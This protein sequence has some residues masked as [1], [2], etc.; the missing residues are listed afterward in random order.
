MYTFALLALL[1]NPVVATVA[2]YGACVDKKSG[3]KTCSW[4]PSHCNMTAEDWLLA[5]DFTDEDMTCDASEIQKLGGC[6][7]MFGGTHVQRCTLS[8][9]E[10][11][12]LTG[13]AHGREYSYTSDTNCPSN[14][15]PH[16][17]TA[18]VGAENGE[19]CTGFQDREDGLLNYGM[20]QN[21][22]TNDITCVFTENDCDTGET[23]LSRA[24]P[25]NEHQDCTCDMVETGACYDGVTHSSF[26]AFD[27]EVCDEAGMTWLDRVTAASYSLGC[28]AC[29]WDY[30]DLNSKNCHSMCDITASDEMGSEAICCDFDVVSRNSR[31]GRRTS[32]ETDLKGTCCSSGDDLVMISR[33]V[34]WYSQ[35]EFEF[36]MTTSM[37]SDDDAEDVLQDTIAEQLGMSVNDIKS[38]DVTTSEVEETYRR[39]SL[40]T[41]SVTWTVKFAIMMSLTE[42]IYDNTADLLE[43]ISTTIA[44]DS[45]GTAVTTDLQ[46]VT[47]FE[48]MTVAVDTD[49]VE[50][51]DT[52]VYEDD[53]NDDDEEFPFWAK[54][55]LVIVGIVLLFA[56]IAAVVMCTKKKEKSAMHEVDGQHV[57]VVEAEAAPAEVSVSK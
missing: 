57:S 34:S 45:F 52:T 1:A 19:Y 49:S 47:G 21:D 20:C 46:A 25:Y 2:T 43:S 38:F 41:D 48:T 54:M 37:D 15:Q 10:M 6:Y 39:R 36:E 18:S 32:P 55:V 11:T 24:D 17:W 40:L 31:S 16:W 23:W 3:D 29:E 14:P 9:S 51:T 35:G 5:S 8:S 56:I 27:E 50:T 44:S 33:D 26:C 7:D 13:F 53:D 12:K 22:E 42:T 28:V 4:S 30:A